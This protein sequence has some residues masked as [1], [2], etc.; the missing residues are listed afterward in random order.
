MTDIKTHKVFV[1]G[2]LRRGKHNHYL[3][4]G[5]TFLGEYETGPGFKKVI[6]GLPYL[7]EE[8]TGDGTEGELYEVS[9]LTLQM[10][11]RLEGHPDWY[12][13]SMITVFKPDKDIGVD[14]WAYLM[15]RERI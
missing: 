2:T 8:D 6:Q 15:P 4:K 7:I 12:V 11:D 10:L 3:L 13:R 14:A 9:E 5:A 1:Y